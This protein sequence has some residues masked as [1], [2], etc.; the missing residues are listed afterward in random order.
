MPTQ[1]DLDGMTLGEAIDALGDEGGKRNLFH[2]PG[3]IKYYLEEEMDADDDDPR[4]QLPDTYD[5]EESVPSL[6]EESKEMIFTE[7]VR[8]PNKNTVAALS[9]S[10]QISPL[11]VE[12]I[13]LL[14]K[15]LAALRKK[16][17]TEGYTEDEKAAIEFGQMVNAWYRE[18]HGTVHIGTKSKKYQQDMTGWKGL[19]AE[20]QERQMSAR[21]RPLYN[22]VSMED[23]RQLVANIEKFRKH[24]DEGMSPKE[25]ERR[26]LERA[27]DGGP[28]VVPME[29]W[30]GVE[31][32]ASKR[33]KYVFA[34]ISKGVK[35]PERWVAVRHPDGTLRAASPEERYRVEK[36]VAPPVHPSRYGTK[37]Y[38]NG[39][40]P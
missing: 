26:R 22:I 39:R 34:D 29:Q 6:S 35:G 5:E 25:R 30:H 10:F 16:G 2:E 13:I 37:F 12:A 23:A 24:I 31:P 20:A 4:S 40:T 28:P 19:L 7:F 36:I 8:D 1:E 15:D 9:E 18:E 11:R 27:A 14:Q 32:T 21:P 3:A 17:E 38:G 33:F